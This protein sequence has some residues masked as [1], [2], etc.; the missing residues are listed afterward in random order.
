[1]RPTKDQSFDIKA[2]KTFKYYIKSYSLRYIL[3]VDLVKRGISI[4]YIRCN[5]LLVIFTCRMAT[6]M[7]YVKEHIPVI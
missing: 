2:K 5:F 6:F 1:M 7:E 3:M 4:E